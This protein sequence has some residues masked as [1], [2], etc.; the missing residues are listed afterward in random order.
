MLLLF[1]TGSYF[2]LV[3]I[4]GVRAFYVQELET[5][6]DFISRTS[7]RFREG[8]TEVEWSLAILEGVLCRE[9]RRWVWW[10]MVLS[11]PE[12]DRALS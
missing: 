1:M 8:K 2:Y 12:G 6:P 7:D 5:C 4:R 3:E 9:N 10:C 11:Q